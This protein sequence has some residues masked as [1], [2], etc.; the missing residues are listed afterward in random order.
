LG[1]KTDLSSYLWN[2]EAGPIRFGTSASQ[3][4]IIDSD[5]HVGIG[6]SV[7]TANLHVEGG[8]KIGS[9]GVTFN[10]LREITGTTGASGTGTSIALPSGYTAENTRVLSYEIKVFGTSWFGLGS[11]FR[12]LP[13]G[14]LYNQSY[15]MVG[16]TLYVYY[17][18]DA[19]YHSRDFRVL[20][21]QI[22]P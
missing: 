19:D 1:I 16:T 11:H 12:A 10:E 4:M 3:R 15:I 22:A 13:A 21:M 8:T 2:Y 6:T 5:G 14:S 17:P 9:S 20:I 7:P 18:N